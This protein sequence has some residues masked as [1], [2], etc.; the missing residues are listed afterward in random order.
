MLSE[1]LIGKTASPGELDLG[2]TN[3]IVCFSFQHAPRDV[4]EEAGIAWPIRN[5]LYLPGAYERIKPLGQ[6]SSLYPRASKVRK[7]A[8]DVHIQSPLSHRSNP[9]NTRKSNPDP[10]GWPRT[11]LTAISRLPKLA[12]TTMGHGRN[13]NWDDSFS[14]LGDE[15][16]EV[17]MGTW[18]TKRT[19]SSSAGDVAMPEYMLASSH[20]LKPHPSW[21]NASP[22]YEQS[23][24]STRSGHRSREKIDKLHLSGCRDDLG[25]TLQ[26]MSP[27]KKDRESRYNLGSQ[28][29]DPMARPPT[30]H[31]YYPPKMGYTPLMSRPS[32]ASMART[33]SYPDLNSAFRN[34]SN[35]GIRAKADEVE[36]NLKGKSFASY[37]SSISSNKENR[38]PS[39][40]RMPIQGTWSNQVPTPNP[41]VQRLPVFDPDLPTREP[42]SS[43]STQP[44]YNYINTMHP[45]DTGKFVSAHGPSAIGSVRSRKE[46]MATHSPQLPQ[47]A[48]RH[49]QSLLPPTSGAPPSA[50]PC[51]SKDLGKHS[52]S[53]QTCIPSVVEIIDVDA[54]DP[55]LEADSVVPDTTKLS[56]F[57]PTHKQGMSSIDSTGRL[58]QQ[59]FS[60]L[61]EELASFEESID[62]NGMGPELA[63][64][65]GGS[66]T[67]TQS[68]PDYGASQTPL[69]PEAHAFEPGGVGKRKRKGTLGGDR[70]RDADRSP[71]SKKEKAVMGKDEVGVF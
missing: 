4:L 48:I 42:I 55:Q 31:A 16:D 30:A 7:P 45:M 38:P 14:A 3:D 9:L 33:S 20:A 51:A 63:R 56:P 66:T 40:I 18:S 41:F 53:A 17:S 44:R 2:I 1:Q 65:I 58:E 34:V 15:G 22:V 46:G 29:G 19:A 27:A 50:Q 24:N 37:P 39:Q 47:Q 68:Q 11:H 32:T 57:K 10:Q 26:A 69:D 12:N 49:D 70:D 43:F 67:R 5:P 35:K 52:H 25:Q 6:I 21:T 54:I 36:N 59:L 28:H 8:P 23:T 13:R 62:A 71:L 61:G 60:A 64:A